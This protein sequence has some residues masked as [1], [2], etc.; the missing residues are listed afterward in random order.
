VGV[1]LG[2]GSLRTAI[3]RGV[4][5]S[6]AGGRLPADTVGLGGLSPR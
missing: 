3:Q 2:L 6:D 1:G 5:L 4:T